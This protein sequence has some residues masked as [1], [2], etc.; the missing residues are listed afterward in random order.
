MYIEKVKRFATEFPL[1]ALIWTSALIALTF[2]DPSRA[3]H[4]T[5]CPIAWLGF[6]FCPGCGLGRSIAWLFHGSLSDSLRT[7]PLGVVTLAVLVHRIYRLSNNH[8][9]HLWQK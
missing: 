5:I 3:D 4:V 8:I 1:E 6:D 9:N 7:H 2:V